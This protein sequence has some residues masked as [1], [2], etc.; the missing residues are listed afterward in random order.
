[1][2]SK[3][4]ARKEVKG[5]FGQIIADYKKKVDLIQKAKLGM[6]HQFFIRKL[7]KKLIMDHLHWR[8]LHYNAGDS[9]SHCLLA[10]A[11][12]GIAT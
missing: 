4:P 1:L 11:T 2:K 6:I 7:S 3:A 9:D 10:L 8:R 5:P 12:L